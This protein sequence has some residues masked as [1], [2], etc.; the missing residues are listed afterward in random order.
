MTLEEPITFVK[1]ISDSDVVITMGQK[2]HFL[3][4]KYTGF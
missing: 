4:L 1:K 3:N 2:M